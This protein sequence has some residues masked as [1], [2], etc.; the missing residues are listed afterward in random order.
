MGGL[1]GGEASFYSFPGWSLGTRGVAE[2]LDSRES[3]NDRLVICGVG[4]PGNLLSGS[5][6]QE[7]QPGR[8]INPYK[9]EVK[10]KASNG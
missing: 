10:L 5:E 3:G 7:G 6:G 9:S 8:S 2:K 4:S 1:G